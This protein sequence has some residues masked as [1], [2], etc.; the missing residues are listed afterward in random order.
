MFT[1][2]SKIHIIA[3]A[4]HSA[5]SGWTNVWNVAPIVFVISSEFGNAQRARADSRAP[6]N[7]YGLRLPKREV[8]LS[9]SAPIIG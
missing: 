8:V 2:A 6:H 9:D 3:A 7:K 5:A 4:K 1:Q